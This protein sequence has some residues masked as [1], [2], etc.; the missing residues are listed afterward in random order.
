MKMKRYLALLL[1][2]VMVLSVFAA[3]IPAYAA[4]DVGI[5]NG[6]GNREPIR[7]GKTFSYR[8]IVNGEF[9]GFGFSMPTWTKTD[10]YATLYIYKWLGGYEKTIASKEFNPLKDGQYHWV[11]FDAQPA[12]EYLFHIANGG[13]DV[14]VWTNTSPTDS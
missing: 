1:C 8:A 5:Q 10:S 3:V 9:T 4:A 11:E 14:G 13:T 2:A 7:V 6:T 12:G